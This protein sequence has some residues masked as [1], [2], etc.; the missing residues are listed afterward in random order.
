MKIAELFVSLGV[1]GDNEAAKAL[2]TTKNMMVEVRDAG[3]ATKA[4][5]LGIVYG[6]EQLMASGMKTGVTMTSFATATGMSA[7]YL[8]RMAYGAAQ[9]GVS[10]D[11]MEGSI[12]G[13]QSAMMKMSIGKG[14]PDGWG[15]IKN[16]VGI[17]QSRIADTKY[18][19]ERLAKYAQT[20]KNI[21]FA[22][23]MLKSMGLSL[24]MISAMRR[25]AFDP[26]VLASAPTFSDGELMQ[27]Q[28]VSAAWGNLHRKWEMGVTKLANKHGMEFVKELSD[29][30]TKM[31]TLIGLLSDFSEK[32][33]LFKTIGAIIEG[34]GLIFE[35]LNGLLTT[36]NGEKDDKD[37]PKT[38][39]VWQMTPREAVDSWFDYKDAE[40]GYN[41]VKAPDAARG[42][43]HNHN[44]NVSQTNHITGVATAKDVEHHVGKALSKHVNKHA[45]ASHATTVRN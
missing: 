16:T 11:E 6:L 41:I 3:L 13:L 25:N 45:R 34:W 30:S 22:N 33:E 37:K 21:P 10:A 42:S 36:I 40:A 14:A 44:T 24:Q 7:D 27:N 2:G 32:V 26:K 19:M 35:Q 9:V 8:Q 28:K 12:T 29:V 1:T 38:K 39:S 5:I 15:V 20:E 4:S 31:I 23:E 17:E 43:T 18:V